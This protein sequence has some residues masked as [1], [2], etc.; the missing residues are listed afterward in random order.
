MNITYHLYGLAELQPRE[1]YVS[2]SLGKCPFIIHYCFLT[3]ISWSAAGCRHDAVVYHLREAEVTNHDLRVL[4]LAVVQDVLWLYGDKQI[5][6]M[7]THRCP[8]KLTSWSRN[9]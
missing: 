2:T 7:F 6:Q 3:D 1:S 4:I 5:A 9:F 8:H